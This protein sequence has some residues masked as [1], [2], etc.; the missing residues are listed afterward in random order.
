MY[1]ASNAPEEFCGNRECNDL[2]VKAKI[3]RDVM[4]G[5][6]AVSA[7]RHAQHIS[8]IWLIMP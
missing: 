6:G 2:I 8:Q 7:I 3:E 4:W 5:G 1:E